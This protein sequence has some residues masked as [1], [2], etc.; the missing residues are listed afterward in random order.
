MTELL[1]LRRPLF[2]AGL[3]AGRL[4]ARADILYLRDGGWD[5]VEVKSGTSVKDPNLDDVAFQ[6][7]CGR[8]AGLRVARCFNRARERRLPPPR[9]GDPAAHS[10]AG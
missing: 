5:I 9:E 3:R 10:Q 8:E 2:E 4:Y 7:L 6:A 1:E